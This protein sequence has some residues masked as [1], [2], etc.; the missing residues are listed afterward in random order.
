MKKEVS[1]ARLNVQVFSSRVDPASSTDDKSHDGSD[2]N[3]DSHHLKRE[4][5][6]NPKFS[7]DMRLFARFKSNFEKIV[8][9]TCPDKYQQAYIMKR[10]CLQGECKKLVENLGDIDKIWER[11]EDRYGNTTEIVNIVLQGI[12]QL[13]FSKNHNERHQ[14]MVKLVDELDRG[15]QDLDAINVKHEIANACLYCENSGR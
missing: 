11:L 5:M 13:Q 15:V 4:K 14:G 7:G 6:Q 9:P 3:S 12:Q 10:S 2:T 1:E 8:V